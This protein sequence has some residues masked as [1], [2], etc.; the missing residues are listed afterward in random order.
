MGGA[1]AVNASS[2]C[3][4]LEDLG[5]AASIAADI[6]DGVV[7]VIGDIGA[8]IADPI[9]F[10]ASSAAS[11]LLNHFKP[12]ED[13][14]NTV[15]GNSGAVNA[16]ANQWEAS[17]LTLTNG[18]N[19]FLAATAKEAGD[20]GGPSGEAA[21]KLFQAMGHLTDMTADFCLGAG[22]AMRVAS[23]LVATV[24]DIIVQVIS[25]VVGDVVSAV[26]TSLV[27]LGAGATVE[28]PKCIAQ[29]ATWASKV[30]KMCAKL[31][32]KIS[33][34][35]TK[36]RTMIEGASEAK[37]GLGSAYKSILNIIDDG[38]HFTNGEADAT[39]SVTSMKDLLSKV[40]KDA[41]DAA[42]DPVKKPTEQVK[43]ALHVITGQTDG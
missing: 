27:T 14:M 32:T 42:S 16:I 23:Y 37:T 11:F 3:I 8:A 28:V 7:T 22:Q 41:V 1:T 20:W 21:Q 36:L 12:L 9:A 40:K 15:V 10:L 35:A 17:A 19:A 38:S 24:H 43:T 25:K 39:R 33:A 26:A 29:I 34:I 4:I 30:G 5:D 13:L 2:G 6:A 18:S 31:S